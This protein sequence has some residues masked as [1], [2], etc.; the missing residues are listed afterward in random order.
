MVEHRKGLNRALF[1]LYSGHGRW[2]SIFRWSMLVF[3]LVTIAIFLVHPLITWHDGVPESKGVWLYVDMAIAIVITLDFFSRLYIERHKW[4]FFLNIIN[5]ADLAVVATLIVPLFAQNLVFLR[6]LR[7][8][9]LVRAYDYLDQRHGLSGW[10]RVNSFVMSK[11]VNLVVFVFLVTAVV[12][13]NQVH[14]N[15]DMHS[16]LDALYFTIGTLTTVGLGDITLTGVYGRWITIAIMVLGITL[17]LQLIR[18]VA[19]GDKSKRTCPACSLDLH[20]RDAAHCKRC[21]AS[22]F[23]EAGTD[24]HSTGG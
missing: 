19:I 5:L 17:F 6:V 3:D 20:D 4:R 21:G 23:P 18:A 10:L 16:Y 14:V 13:V 9:R 11:I 1:W 15:E 2:P 22:L 24:H 12:Y 8:V 7:V